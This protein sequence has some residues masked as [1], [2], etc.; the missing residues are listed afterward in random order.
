MPSRTVDAKCERTDTLE[1]DDPPHCP[2]PGSPSKHRAPRSGL[3]P[4]RHNPQPER[5]RGPWPWLAL[6]ACLP[7]AWCCLDVLTLGATR[8]EPPDAAG[9]AVAPDAGEE[10]APAPVVVDTYVDA[11]VPLQVGR[12]VPSS[13]ERW[14]KRPPCLKNVEEARGG[15]CYIRAARKPPCPPELYEDEGACFVAVGAARRPDTSLGR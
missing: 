13:P 15:A 12:A 7:L 10:F 4:R 9:L 14:Q 8:P 6:A 11:S 3:E 1:M 5:V 2:A